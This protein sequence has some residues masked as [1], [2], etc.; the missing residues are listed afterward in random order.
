MEKKIIELLCENARL[1]VGEL[2]ERCGVGEDKVA[3][4]IKSLEKQGIIRGYTAILDD[5]ALGESRV[6]ALASTYWSCSLKRT[7]SCCGISLSL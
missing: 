1:S 5:R 2:A 7:C 6:K 3:A 4:A